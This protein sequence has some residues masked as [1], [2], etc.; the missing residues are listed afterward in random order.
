MN[1]SRTKSI[2]ILVFLVLNSFLGYQLWEKIQTRPLEL[3][4]LS[5]GSVEELLALRNI[6]LETELQ[7]EQPELSQ[8]NA[9]FLTNVFEDF[10]NLQNQS[11]LFQENMLISQFH[12]PILLEEGQ[13]QDIRP[14]VEPYIHRFE[15][16]ELDQWAGD[17][18]LFLQK[19]EGHPIF[20]GG[21]EFYVN[22]VEEE[23]FL[24]GYEQTY[25][26]VVNMGTKQPTISSYTSIRTLL[27]NQAIPYFSTIVD[28][29]LGYYGQVYEVEG[30]VLTPAWRI[31][32]ET[33]DRVRMIYVN[34]ITGA[35]ETEYTR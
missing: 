20:I 14:L 30:Q 31:M 28:V 8:L 33:D 4:Q 27:D 19:V 9:Q 32:I 3:A 35:I 15:Q 16:Y 2:F 23:L 7:A 12:D 1:W 24:T 29:R 6:S 13:E 25:Y 5:E 11:L 10:E 21:I 34:A 17:S 22:Q 26:Q 18:I